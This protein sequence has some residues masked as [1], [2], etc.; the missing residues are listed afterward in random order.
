[1][2]VC[3]GVRLDGKSPETPHKLDRSTRWG[4]V[5]WESAAW[6]GRLLVKLSLV[7]PCVVSVLVRTERRTT[8][9]YLG[10]KKRGCCSYSME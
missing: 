2:C 3:A 8:S 5:G 10:T 9:N 1:M 4:E 7:A 6:A